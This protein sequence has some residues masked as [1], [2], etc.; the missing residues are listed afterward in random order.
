MGHI[1]NLIYQV[2]TCKHHVMLAGLAVIF[3]TA[4]GGSGGQDPDPLVEDYGI[5]YVRHPVPLDNT[6]NLAQPDIREAIPFN[7]GAD[8]YYRE[9][10]SPSAPERN[11]TRVFT[12]GQGDVKDVE[13]SYDGDRLL[14]AMRAPEI[15]GADPE[16]QPKWNIWEYE[17]SS[18]ESRRIISS[19]IT[20]EAGDDVAPHYLPDGRIVFSSTRQRQSRAILL[21]ESKPQ[22]SALDESRN[23]PAVVLHVM[24]SDGGDIHQISFNQSHD[25]DPMVLS[26]GEVV[27]SR[28]DH[29]GS[30]DAISL[31]KMHPDGSE[32]KLLYGAHSHDTGTNGSEVQFLQPREMDN[33]Q[34]LTVMLP[35]TDSNRGGQLVALDIANYID[36]NQPKTGQGLLTRPAQ[37]PLT[38]NTVYTDN[39]IS[40]GGRF[41][42]AWPMQDGTNRMLVS[43]SECRLIESPLIVP[44]TPDRLANPAAVEANPIYGVFVYNRDDDTQLPVVA[45]EEG[46][47]FTDVV[48]AAPRP[49]PNII[50]DKVAGGELDP[51]SFDEGVGILN[52]RSVY[53]LDGVD[54]TLTGIASLAD[55]AQYTADERPARF[56]RI[57]KAVG[58]PDDEVLDF[59]NSA[60]GR[61]SQQL[62]REII[63]YV[64][65]QPDGSVK[66]KV[67]AN[68]PLAISVLDK[69]GRRISNRHQ[70][71]LQVR[72]GETVNCVGCHDHGS[73]APHS[74]PGGP[75][76]VYPGA[77]VTGLPFPNTDPDLFANFGET[78][79]ET[80]TRLDSLEL[81]PSVDP[82][83]VDL[84]THEPTAGRP[85]DASFSLPYANLVTPAPASFA[86]Q[87]AW[88][89]ACR[90]VIH[91][92]QHIHPLWNRD[93]GANTCTSCHSTTDAAGMLRVPLGQLDL[94]DGLSSAD[95]NHFN[96]YRE[97]LFPDFAEEIGVN[98]LQD[99]IGPVNVP[100]SMSTAGAMASG[101][102]LDR[103][104]A[105]NSH[106]GRLDPAELRLITEWLDIG[107][108]YFNDPFAAPLN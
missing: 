9:L 87:T 41:R 99:I 56:L 104:A 106:D 88:S 81:L 43:W 86:C 67:P 16:D 62:M 83:Y 101:T 35:F 11:I 77:Q 17:I 70:N 22:F 5:A 27:F 2:C 6:G 102:F 26:S 79:A 53:D 21:D 19:D 100:A 103:F 52:I 73:G 24:N 51:Q 78:M 85:A 8:L 42:A 28:W 29:M 105:G 34:L 55:P 37:T 61:S 66:L 97:L 95:A 65:V 32:S 72:A 3:V 94:S 7:A 47:V 69:D 31:Y 18:G 84:W 4:C 50:F 93:R 92:E 10:A 89:N 46:I 63:G 23:E 98:G 30:Q 13:V 91:Y 71:W 90:T 20:A 49:L 14:F 82:V 48:V 39:S 44:C 58:I 54:T 12:G 59:S 76:S 64:P 36:N 40:P 96:A 80:L 45:P 68:V 75:A 1:E 38:I 60:F 74:H 57:V 108:Q 15:E 33:G 25:I 107:A